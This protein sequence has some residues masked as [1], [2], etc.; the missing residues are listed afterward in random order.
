MRNLLLALSGVA[1]LATAGC[2]SR[3]DDD[4]RYYRD[5]HYDRDRYEHRE[6]WHDRDRRDDTRRV[7]VCDE[8][9]DRCHWEYRNP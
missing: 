3:Y 4:G 8:D 2:A 9:G 6:Y 5:G 1:L 7:R